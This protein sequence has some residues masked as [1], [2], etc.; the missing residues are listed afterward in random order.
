MNRI[1]TR[2][3]ALLLCAAVLFSGCSGSGSGGGSEEGGTA[4]QTEPLSE[5]TLAFA[6]SDGTNPYLSQNTITYQNAPLLYG[7]LVTIPPSFQ[8]EMGLASAVAVNGPTVTIQ[9][10]T[11]FFADGAPVTAGDAA[12]SLE[13]ARQSAVYGG[14]FTNVS[15]VS[16]A[17]STVTI[18][19]NEPDSLF[20]YL[21]DIPVMKASQV[22]AATPTGSGR[23]TPVLNEE[24]ALVFS[25]NPH[26]DGSVPVDTIRLL[27][28]SGLD[29]LVSSLNIGDVSLYSSELEQDSGSIACSTEY[30]K[31]NSLVF[32][33]LNDGRG[34]RQS[35]T[36]RQAISSAVDRSVL[37]EKGYFSRAYPATG[38]L[39]GS[40]PALG[41]KQYLPSTADRETAAQQMALG[42][43]SVSE[44]DGYAT[45]AN[46]QRLN[47]KLLVCTQGVGKRYTANLIR[48]QLAAAGIAVEIEE[49][50]SFE[51]YTRRVSAGDFDM[52]IGEVKLYNNMDIGVF[53]KGGAA[54]YGVLPSEGLLNAYAAFRQD[55]A[56]ADAFET[57]FADEVP[58]V[59]LLF[60]RGVVSYSRGITGVQ[61]SVSDVFYQ[62]E[63]FAAIK[64]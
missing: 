41:G 56:A 49:T 17:G 55:T 26:Y 2:A 3:A 24:S 18:T 57:A 32:L 33:G 51:E 1:H 43:Y 36:V 59:P 25:K 5:F 8:L 35:P 16:A 7:Q 14:R 10:R 20:A 42:G 29:A 44:L 58:Y 38:A 39:N 40:Y 31:T 4:L 48:E 37:C 61:P 6:K 23:Y 53:L 13:A 46:G 63:Q 9:M 62:F 54:S 45:D 12:A 28:L 34:A 22:G 64:E 21:L 52:Y 15:A 47:L 30:Y 11:A 60:R 19:L 27:E 50:D